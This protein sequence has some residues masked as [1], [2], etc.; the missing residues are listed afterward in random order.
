MKWCLIP[1]MCAFTLLAAHPGESCRTLERHGK[2]HEANSCFKKLTA[3]NSAAARA[4]GL[5][6][7]RDYK[8]A[9]KQFEVAV[10]Q[11][12]TNADVRVRWGRLFLER[13]NPPDAQ[14]LFKEAL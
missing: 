5:W 1:L 10:A 7:L 6:G 13:F 8:S 9:S 4:E 14:N 12:P 11:Q 2:R 3:G